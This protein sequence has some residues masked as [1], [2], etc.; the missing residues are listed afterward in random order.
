MHE[1]I[2]NAIEN[3]KEYDMQ[4]R[5]AFHKAIMNDLKL[6]SIVSNDG[7][8]RNIKGIKGHMTVIGGH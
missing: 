7:I 3:I 5:D 1:G 4:P 8:F 2:L 6:E